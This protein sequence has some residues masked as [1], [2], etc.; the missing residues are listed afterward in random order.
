MLID[1]YN[2]LDNHNLKINI[3][4]EFAGLPPV[5]L[6]YIKPYLTPDGE[7]K[8]VNCTV[9]VPNSIKN[10]LNTEYISNSDS[11][12]LEIDA[13]VNVY[14]E[15][16]RG[17]LYGILSLADKCR[18]GI[19]KGI[20]YSYPCVDFRM[21]KLYLPSEENFEYFKEFID[22]CL[23]YGYNTVMLE[24]GGAMEYKSHPEVNEGWIEYSKIASDHINKR[25]DNPHF[26]YKDD[27][28][29]F[30]KNSIH[31]ENA[32]GG[33]ISQKKVKELVDYCRDRFMEVIPE[34]PTLSHSDYLLT[35][36]PELAERDDDIYPDC[37]CPSNPDTY[38]LVFDLFKEVI[39]VFNPQ[40]MNI[41]HDEAYSV[42][43]CEKCRKKDAANIFAD[44]IIK[45]HGFLEENNVKTMMWSDKLINCI[46][47]T[48][49]AWAGAY[50]EI[51]NPSTGEIAQIIMP[52]H[53]AVDMIPGDIQIVHWYW[54]LEENTEKEFK[55][56]GLYTV[57]GNFEPLRVKNIVNRLKDGVCGIGISN[58]SKVDL[59][60]MHRNG[61]Y[62]DVAHSAY[63]M[64][65]NDY[66]E[67]AFDENVKKVA[68]DLYCYR[69]GNSK[70]KA[71]ILH[72]F[73]KDIP[74]V[75]FLDGYEVDKEANVI[76]EYRIE[77]ADG[78][79]K[80]VPAE[81]GKTIG[82]TGVNRRYSDSDWCESYETD[83]RLIEPAYSCTFEF[84]V[85]NKTYYRFAVLAEKPISGLKLILKD[86]YA[87]CVEV[88]EIVIS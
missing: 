43:I 53:T 32:G 16:Q 19:G 70:C 59:L 31:C 72:G 23:Y 71:E 58:W 8:K 76:G 4:A 50:R 6:K 14:A 30:L 45:I 86:E 56:K 79:F 62:Y 22:L 57:F 73:T 35:K 36:H 15:S 83:R 63:I 44:D 29:Y 47:K 61:I 11:Y 21:I 80:S 68:D 87:D 40:R 78:T 5:C 75:L 3:N 12:I 7:I 74:F 52:T 24:V 20:V 51:K 66:D 17:I 67:N 69:T 42:G 85:D 84:D 33:V 27:K 38:K 13:E 37:Y 88:K 60:H 25:G 46:D 48:G 81:Y 2:Y 9:G 18:K 82:Y 41:G 65:R 34:M 28:T 64:W 49:V 1:R 39:D 77:F 26:P 54:S 10:K 55:N